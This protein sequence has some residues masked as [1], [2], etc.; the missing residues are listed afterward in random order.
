M[1]SKERMLLVFSMNPRYKEH[2]NFLAL[3]SYHDIF[4]NTW[5]RIYKS[6]CK[7]FNTMQLT[8]LCIYV[9]T[10]ACFS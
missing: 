10:I 3:K 8:E 6:A 1:Y 5:V 2:N 9:Y 4:L 7:Y